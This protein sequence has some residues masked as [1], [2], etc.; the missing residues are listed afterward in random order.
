MYWPGFSVSDKM[1]L[2]YRLRLYL[3]FCS[4]DSALGFPTPAK[5]LPQSTNCFVS[6]LPACKPGNRMSICQI[7]LYSVLVFLLKFRFR[8]LAKQK[9]PVYDDRAFVLFLRVS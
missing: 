9:S 4:I 6:C 7:I 2:H 8:P 1:L 5:R 3:T